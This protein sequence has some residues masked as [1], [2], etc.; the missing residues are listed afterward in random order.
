MIFYCIRKG[1]EIK[2][3]KVFNYCMKKKCKN[4]RLFRNKVR[5][6]NYCKKIAIWQ[7][8]YPN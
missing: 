8:S 4:Y 3:G 2:T 1:E 7:K 6:E 5:L